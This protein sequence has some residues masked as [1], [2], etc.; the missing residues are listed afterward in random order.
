MKFILIFIT[1]IL[2]L[3]FSCTKKNQDS[4]YDF[5]VCDSLSQ[6]PLP[7]MRVLLLNFYYPATD[8]TT[9][10]GYTDNKGYFRYV[11]DKISKK[12]TQYYSHWWIGFTS[13]YGPNYSFDEI[14][15][16]IPVDNKPKHNIHHVKVYQA[17]EL[18]LNVK[19]TT[20][21]HPITFI[22]VSTSYLNHSCNYNI[23][24]HNIYIKNPT[25]QFSSDTILPIE[26]NRKLIIDYSL[27]KQ[28]QSGDNGIFKTQT[29][30][31]SVG[32]N[33]KIIYEIKW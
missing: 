25:Q 12:E 21:N 31:I 22:K 33:E 2:V 26:S 18:H 15:N 3:L 32:Y 28:S 9:T 24:C 16:K 27:Y 14:D 19:L 13:K 5:Y 30:T 20:P 10:I 23:N 11:C 17:S 4:I 1:T 29:D 7:D 6:E 8:I